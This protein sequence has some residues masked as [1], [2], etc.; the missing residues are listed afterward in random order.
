MS[1][2]SVRY[3]SCRI[4]HS[5]ICK[6]C[7]LGELACLERLVDS[8]DSYVHTVQNP[9]LRH[10]K[11]RSRTVDHR[12]EVLRQTTEYVLACLPDLVAEAT[13]SMHDFDIKVDIP[14]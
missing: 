12:S 5:L 2:S 1:L 6:L 8:L 9:P 11:L 7:A 13:I 4:Q 14:A 10:G 3:Q